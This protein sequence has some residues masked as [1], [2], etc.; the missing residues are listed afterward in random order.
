MQASLETTWPLAAALNL[1]AFVDTREK[2]STAQGEKC[3]GFAKNIFIA[4]FFNSQYSV[5]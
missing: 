5:K 4:L 1:C 3:G 2:K